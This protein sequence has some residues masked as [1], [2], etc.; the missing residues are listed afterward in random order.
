VETSVDEEQST[1]LNEAGFIVLRQRK[2][3]PEAQFSGTWS[4][5]VP[6]TSEDCEATDSDDHAVEIESFMSACRVAHYV[7]AITKEYRDSFRSRAS[8]E[9]WIRRWIADYVVPAYM[10]DSPQFERFPLRGAK[11]SIVDSERSDE[12]CLVRLALHLLAQ[13]VPVELTIPIF[14][15]RAVPMAINTEPATAEPRI[16][17]GPREAPSGREKFL[18]QLFVAEQYLRWGRIEAA[19]AILEGLDEQVERFHL[20]EWESPKV[21][22]TVWAMLRQCYR[23]SPPTEDTIR[24]SAKLLRRCCAVGPAG[25]LE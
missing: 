18:Y 12:H 7:R 22:S 2:G 3:A 4:C 19:T 25:L 1:A 21:I 17:A 6:V 11:V 5:H 8:C 14:L 10:N 20:L 16:I 24:R 9:V 13:A 15:P 23:L